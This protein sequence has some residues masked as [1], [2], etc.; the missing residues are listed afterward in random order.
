[1]REEID[2][3][4]RRWPCFVWG[5]WENKA[6]QRQRGELVPIGEV[7]ADL[8]GPVKAIRE[9]S[10]QA[11]HHF[12]RF[13]AER[14]KL[15]TAYISSVLKP[16]VVHP[17]ENAHVTRR[18]N[19]DHHVSIRGRDEGIPGHCGFGHLC[20]HPNTHRRVGGA[21]VPDASGA[22][23]EGVKRRL[24]RGFVPRV[25]HVQMARRDTYA[26][27]LPG[28]AGRRSVPSDRRGGGPP[29]EPRSP[30]SPDREPA[31]SRRRPSR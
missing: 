4:T 6:M 16:R 3:L 7:V 22:L 1:M 31:R 13:V 14:R 29:P 18:G 10:P 20:H 11:R 25:D 30:P 27:P 19:V 2:R 9:A 15:G 26:Q 12:T 17:V 21:E 5:T 8:D 23:P 28:T 24:G